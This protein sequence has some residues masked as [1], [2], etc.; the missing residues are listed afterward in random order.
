MRR[1]ILIVAIFLLAGTVVN[2]A[3]ALGVAIRVAAP[4]LRTAIADR[5]GLL[6]NQHTGDQWWCQVTSISPG[7]TMVVLEYARKVPIAYSGDVVTEMREE[8]TVQAEPPALQV[9]SD[10]R[11]SL[12]WRTQPRV[13]FQQVQ[14]EDLVPIEPEAVPRWVRSP[15]RLYTSGQVHTACGW[16]LLSLRCEEAL[17]PALRGRTL[18]VYWGWLLPD[19][20]QSL[21]P[22]RVLPYRLIA[23]GFAV[24]TLL[25]AVVLWLLIPGP[26]ALRRFIRVRRG[27]CPACAY[28]HGESDVCSECG[29]TLPRRV[30]SS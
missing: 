22:G 9:G 19:A 24:N 17:G 1:G 13:R 25:Y 14:R 2:V 30:L 23:P 11:L 6:V 3:V 5:E 15:V 16:P 4:N 8:T 21:G 7:H 27:L 18:K 12:D 20:F 10:G 29:K 26:F 28:P